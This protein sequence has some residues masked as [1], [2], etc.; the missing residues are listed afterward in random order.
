MSKGVLSG[1]N[2]LSVEYQSMY[3]DSRGNIKLANGIDHSDPCRP[4][5]VFGPGFRE[6]FNNLALLERSVL[7][8]DRTDPAVIG[9]N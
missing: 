6:E 2:A 4:R 1:P 7:A 8:E 3:R 5:C 9:N